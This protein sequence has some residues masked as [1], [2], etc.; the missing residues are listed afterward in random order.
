MQKEKVCES[1]KGIEANRNR[2]KQKRF[3]E[4]KKEEGKK[5]FRIWVTNGEEKFLREIILPRLNSLGKIHK[6]YTG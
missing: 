3:R 2:E 1:K 4:R 6:K 5:E